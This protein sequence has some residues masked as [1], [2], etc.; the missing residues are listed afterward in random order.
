MALPG[1]DGVI[2]TALTGDATVNGIVG[3][4]VYALQAPAGVALP[5]IVFYL[6]SGVV[7]NTQPR[8][9][10]NTVYRVESRASTRAGAQALADAVFDVLHEAS[11]ST[12]GWSIYWTVVEAE[13]HFIENYDGVQVYRRVIDVRL[14]G[15][16]D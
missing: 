2:Y 16:K 9:D 13:Q 14:R 5:Y 4:N 7:P 12:S 8:D 11:L 1:L 6:A 3:T 10:F 15:S